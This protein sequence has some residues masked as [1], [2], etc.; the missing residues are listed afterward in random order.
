MADC[1][2]AGTSE[3]SED[4]GS[5]RWRVENVPIQV[6]VVG[7]I[8]RSGDLDICLKHIVHLEFPHAGAKAH[9]HALQISVH[10]DNTLVPQEPNL[11]LAEVDDIRNHIINIQL[12]RGK[13]YY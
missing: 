11:I 8:K 7:E 12:G 9:P 4:G 2:R 1:S 13:A 3:G 6:R 5:G 10:T